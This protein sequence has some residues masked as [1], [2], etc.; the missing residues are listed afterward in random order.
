MDFVI[1]PYVGAGNLRLGMTTQEVREI[2][3]VEPEP[4]E[5][6]AREQSTADL[7][8]Q[9]GIVVFYDEQ[10]RSEAIEFNGPAT[11]A[12]DG[13][14]LLRLSQDSATAWLKKVDPDAQIDLP[15]LT[16]N[17]LG[18]ALFVDDS[19][20]VSVLVFKKGYFNE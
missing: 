2:M 3:G 6:A 12:Y 4:L 5:K 13:Q 20:V 10:G 11:P 16:S 1:D 17:K 15:D 14:S 19:Q 18:I 7:F 9:Q 8:E